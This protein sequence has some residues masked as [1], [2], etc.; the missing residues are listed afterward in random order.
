MILLTLGPRQSWTPRISQGTYF[1]GPAVGESPLWI[2]EPPTKLLNLKIFTPN[3]PRP[4]AHHREL[5]TL[6]KTP[7]KPRQSKRA[8][9]IACGVPGI[10]CLFC[11][12][13]TQGTEAGGPR[14]HHKMG[15]VSTRGPQAL[16]ASPLWGYMRIYWEVYIYMYIE[17]SR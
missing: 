9:L 7:A 15:P 6:G 8:G 14:L 12:S 1:G 11:T 2:E 4:W 13:V 5:L 17:T 16:H 3:S 10:R